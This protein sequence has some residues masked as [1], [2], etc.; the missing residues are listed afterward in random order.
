MASCKNNLSFGDAVRLVS[1][2]GFGTMVKPVGSACNLRCSYCYYLEKAQ[3]Y[4]NTEPVMSKELLEIY[5]RQYIEANETDE[6]SFC[7][8]GGEPLL[9]G[10]DFYRKA[11]SLQQKYAGSK[12]ITNS[13]QTNGLKVNEE[14]CRFFRDNNFLIGISLDGPRDI[15]D[16]FRKTASDKP[17][18]DSV[19]PAIGLFHRFSVEFNTLS[20]VSSASEGRGGEIYR[21]FRNEAGSHYM[22]FLPAANKRL[23]WT[24]SAKGY[25]EFLTDVFDEWIKRDVG[26]FYVQ[27]FDATLA[28]W[29]GVTPGTC[30]INDTCCDSLT[31]EHN[32]D[33]YACDHFVDKAHC[34]GNIK[35]KTLLEIFK[36]Q[37]R[38]A[39]AL[40]KRETLSTECKRCKYCFTCF[41]ECPEHRENGKN[42]LCEGLYGYFE[43]VEPYMQ[44][45]KELLLQQRSPSEIMLSR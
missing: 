31:V 43:H 17:T 21:F 1:P 14:W 9:A 8:H 5:I 36:S 40:D 27:L 18:F 29:C 24:I 19:M 26:Q 25:G 42:V 11:I 15:Q 41:G 2:V 37:E 23:P 45:M 34:L 44:K 22:Q 39:F 33:V 35:E 20:V 16:H 13:L 38:F 12:K 7:W 28:R 30:S 6:V 4:G 32:G 10:I 3:L